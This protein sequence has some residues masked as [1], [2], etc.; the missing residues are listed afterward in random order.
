MEI[1]T[2]DF[3]GKGPIGS[4]L[5][6][7]WSSDG[8]RIGLVCNGWL[9]DF[10]DLKKKTRDKFPTGLYPGTKPSELQAYHNRITGL[11]DKDTKEIKI[12]E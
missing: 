10:Y 12:G 1:G 5:S 2:E 7:I 6:T 11:L 4:L 3:S 8:N 9:V